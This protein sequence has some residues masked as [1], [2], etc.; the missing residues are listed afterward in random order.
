MKVEIYIEHTFKSPRRTNGVYGY[1][2]VY[3][4][5]DGKE[6]T[7]TVIKE[8]EATPH[9]ADLKAAVEALSRLNRPCE[10]EI[11]AGSSYLKDA[12]AAGWIERWEANGWKNAKGEPVANTELWQKLTEE[13]KK[14]TVSWAP[15]GSFQKWL[16]TEVTNR[17][18]K[19]RGNNHV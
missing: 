1:I 12:K 17:K 2:L 8:M 13:E 5:P 10:V 16:R 6:A 15:S 18:N 11:I 14:H 19:E 4:A 3:R 7:K 9:E